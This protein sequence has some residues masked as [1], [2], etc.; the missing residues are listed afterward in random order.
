MKTTSRLVPL[1][2]ALFGFLRAITILS[3]MAYTFLFFMEPY[4][5]SQHR[6][7]QVMTVNLE[8]ASLPMRI[9]R[10]GQPTAV[11]LERA[12]G[13]LAITEAASPSDPFLAIARSSI[14][15]AKFV[16][17]AFLVALFHLLWVL[18][19]NLEIREVF[20]DRNLVLVRRLGLTLVTYA[21]VALAVDTWKGWRIGGYAAEHFTFEGVKAFTPAGHIGGF[22]GLFDVLVHYGHFDRSLFL[23]GLGV[24]VL[25]EVFR[26]GLALKH[27]ADLTV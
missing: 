19:K 21:V 3:L 7:S 11:A 8:L 5:L 2:R 25:A 9:T 24:L 15:V 4:L 16:H 1:L 10:A 6:Q 18:F 27:D 23:T 12:S 22:S 14:F 20:S 17:G 26:Q 13:D